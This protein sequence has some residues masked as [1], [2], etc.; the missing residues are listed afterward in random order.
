[1]QGFNELIILANYTVL[2]YKWIHN[3]FMMVFIHKNEGCI[4]LFGGTFLLGGG[5]G[6][7]PYLGPPPHADKTLG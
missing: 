1:M 5:G 2:L 7:E 3:Q 4:I 6:G